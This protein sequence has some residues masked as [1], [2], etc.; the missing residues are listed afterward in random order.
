MG[1][2]DWSGGVRQPVGD[3]IGGDGPGPD[4][5]RPALTL[6]S[7]SP[8]SLS[9]PVP[10]TAIQLAFSCLHPHTIEPHLLQPNTT[11]CQ[12]SAQVTNHIHRRPT[13]HVTVLPEVLRGT[14]DPSP[15]SG[16]A[17]P[18]VSIKTVSSSHPVCVSSGESVVN[19]D[20][21]GIV[22]NPTRSSRRSCG[23]RAT[24]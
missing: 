22:K 14:P 4:Q 20:T 15:Q 9:N 3:I 16:I 5:N 10:P 6:T 18:Y 11:P 8:L 21:K 1:S 19:G 7:T 23:A 12:G 17:R 13:P 24:S 2:A